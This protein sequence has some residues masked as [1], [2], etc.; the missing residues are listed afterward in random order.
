MVLIP[1]VVL[2]LPVKRPQGLVWPKDVRI[3]MHMQCA[4]TKNGLFDYIRLKD[5]RCSWM[6]TGHGDLYLPGQLI[7]QLESQ[8]GG[9]TKVGGVN[10]LKKHISMILPL[11]LKNF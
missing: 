9:T 5:V 2:F 4:T 1:A 6:A 7:A 10:A 8:A 3:L 11:Q